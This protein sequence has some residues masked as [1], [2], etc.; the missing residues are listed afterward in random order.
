[1]GEK[2]G[3]ARPYAHTSVDVRADQSAVRVPSS[4]ARISGPSP[5]FAFLFFRTGATASSNGPHLTRSNNSIANRIF[6]KC[7]KCSETAMS[8]TETTGFCKK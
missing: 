1:M 3:T 8:E 7:Q 4:L 6:F 5:S 2:E